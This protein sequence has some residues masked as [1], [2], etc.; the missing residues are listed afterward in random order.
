MKEMTEPFIHN[1]TLDTVS[2][3][4]NHVNSPDT[5]RNCS[6]MAKSLTTKNEKA[7]DFEIKITINAVKAK[8]QLEI[9]GCTI[10]YH[11]CSYSYEKNIIM[12]AIH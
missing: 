3:K 5:I 4:H 1:K 11:L 9:E 12:I 8:I 6:P 2:T 10:T 7:S